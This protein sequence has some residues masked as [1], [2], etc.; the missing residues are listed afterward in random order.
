MG[1]RTDPAGIR[2]MTRF[3]RIIL[4]EGH[5]R[6]RG[7]ITNIRKPE[8]EKVSRRPQRAGKEPGPM[9]RPRRRVV[10]QR[11][12]E[13]LASQHLEIKGSSSGQA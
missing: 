7:R 3:P 8:R 2:V 1:L 5:Q 9:S 11:D 10:R 12:R 6:E 4:L 13:Q